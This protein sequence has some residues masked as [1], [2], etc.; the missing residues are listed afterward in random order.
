MKPKKPSGGA[1]FDDL[2]GKLVQVPKQETD[3]KA[4]AWKKARAKKKRKKPGPGS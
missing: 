3:Q 1:A 4:K 2:L